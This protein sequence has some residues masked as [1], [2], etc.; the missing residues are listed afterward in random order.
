MMRRS[1]GLSCVVAVLA[2]V[3][4][5]GHDGTSVTSRVIGSG[6]VASESRA[7]TPFSSLV[8]T[9]P[10][11]VQM[12][13]GESG[14]IEITAEDNVLPLVRAEVTGDRLHL[15]LADGSLTTTH[16]IR[17]RLAS[18]GLREVEGSGA[19]QIEVEGLA[20]ERLETR[21]ST[22]SSL[23][24][25]GRADQHELRLSD[26]SRCWARHLQSRGVTAFLSGASN[27]LVAVSESLSV[28]GSGASTLEYIG[29]PLLTLDVSGTSVVRRVGP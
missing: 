19:A 10:L 25:S 27:G 11:Q 6:V 5:C 1:V 7:V 23:V 17:I 20:V 29:D 12:Q 18:T 26:A 13:A 2:L 14:A 4:G 28:R 21:L 3:P 8:V 22:A 9:G 16:A 15:F 24:V